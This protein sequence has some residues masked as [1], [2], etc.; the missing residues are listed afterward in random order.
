MLVLIYKP[1]LQLGCI[2]LLLT[3]ESS[4]LSR[5]T[6]FLGFNGRLPWTQV[7]LQKEITLGVSLA[8]TLKQEFTTVLLKEIT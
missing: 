4:T 2:R 5:T 1:M 8:H 7:P 6:L 3:L